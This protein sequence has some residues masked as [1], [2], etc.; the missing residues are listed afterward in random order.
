MTGK[1]P[2]DFHGGRL[3][4]KH[5]WDEKEWDTFD[6]TYVYCL[7]QYIKHGQQKFDDNVLQERQLHKVVYGDQSLLEEMTSFIEEL[8][9]KGGDVSKEEVVA[10]YTYH[11]EFER[12]TTYKSN[13]K[14]T[15]FKKVCAGLRHRINP[16]YEG[17]RC[18]KSVNGEN[19]DFYHVVP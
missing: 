7:D 13:W 11:L 2:A 9:K 12:F 6:T 17:N 3:L 4:D 19:K 15:T 10:F 14:T 18:L 16:D 5:I 8:V 1:T